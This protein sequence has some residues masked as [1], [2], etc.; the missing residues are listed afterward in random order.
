MR[1]SARRAP[2]LALALLVVGAPFAAPCAAQSSAPPTVGRPPEAALRLRGKKLDTRASLYEGTADLAARGWDARD[3]ELRVLGL[4]TVEASA[5]ERIEPELLRLQALARHGDRDAIEALALVAA[6][7]R[8]RA[9]RATVLDGAA[10]G[11]RFG[12]VSG[13]LLAF[14]GALLLAAVLRK[15][16]LVGAAARVTP[17][18]S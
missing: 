5:P 11:A 2:R 8:P 7:P 4:E 12:I 9:D 10:P 13:A 3:R 6:P 16:R 15:R 18:A 1:T 17:A 14:A